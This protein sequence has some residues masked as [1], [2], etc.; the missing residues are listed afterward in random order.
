MNN[1]R[2]NNNNNDNEIHGKEG[3]N[4]IKMIIIMKI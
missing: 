2:G 3:K 1:E 4:R